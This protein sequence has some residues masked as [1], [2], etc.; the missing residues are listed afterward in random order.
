MTIFRLDLIEY[1]EE[2]RKLPF[3]FWENLY[4]NHI[5]PSPECHYCRKAIDVAVE[6]VSFDCDCQLFF[7]KDCLVKNCRI[8]L[9]PGCNGIRKGVYT[10]PKFLCKFIDK[11]EYYQI[12]RR[13]VE[14]LLD[15]E[16]ILDIYRLWFKT[17]WIY[18]PLFLVL[19]DFV[20][21]HQPLD[22]QKYILTKDQNHEFECFDPAF[23]ME[24]DGITYDPEPYFDR[25]MIYPMEEFRER[26]DEYT[27]GLLSGAGGFPFRPE[28][29][30]LAGGAVHKC[31]DRRVDLSGDQIKE[32]SNIDIF[33]CHLD[34]KEL[35][36]EFKEV[37]KYFRKIHQDKIIFVH[38]QTNVVRLYFP[39]FSRS[40]QIVLFRNDLANIVSRFDWSHLQYVYDGVTVWSSLDGI[41]Y[42]NCLFS[43]HSGRYDVHFGKRFQKAKDLKLCLVMPRSKSVKFRLKDHQVEIDS[44]YPSYDDHLALIK[45]HIWMTYRIPERYVTQG[46][47]RRM[48]YQKIPSLSSDGGKSGGLSWGCEIPTE[49]IV[50]YLN[51]E[52]LDATYV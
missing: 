48:N 29:T 30:V 1:Q 27:Y 23:V 13:S 37:V 26:L 3:K 16:Q 28:V 49:N 4:L 47:P 9:C 24:D 17:Y 7:H 42:F 46:K 5:Q 45:R 34:P 21:E 18:A 38:K 19:E 51:N 33:I 52:T 40:V 25:K 36:K 31:L 44:W 41:E 39:G 50:S 20:Q 15:K 12:Y 2:Y 22:T 43:C 6:W 14:G 8:M 35:A 32:Y 11:E 10:F